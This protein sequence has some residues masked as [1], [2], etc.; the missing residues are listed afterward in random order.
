M[1]LSMLMPRLIAL[2]HLK[3]SLFSQL[4]SP[5]SKLFN[6]ISGQ[7]SEWAS[8]SMRAYFSEQ[9]RNLIIYSMPH[10]EILL[11]FFA[12]WILLNDMV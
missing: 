7:A 4:A 1:N 3:S 5:T 11:A 9:E 8:M 2:A 12:T 10:H 6:D